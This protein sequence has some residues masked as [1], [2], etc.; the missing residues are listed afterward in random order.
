MTI[1]GPYVALDPLFVRD[2]GGGADFQPDVS[3]KACG[4]GWWRAE[5]RGQSGGVRCCIEP[6]QI[7][8]DTRLVADDNAGIGHGVFQCWN[9]AAIITGIGVQ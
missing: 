4:G 5:R 7:V 3:S 9:R 2:D 1:P 8:M 6:F